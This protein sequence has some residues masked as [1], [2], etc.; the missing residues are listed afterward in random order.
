ML[1]I[2]QNTWVS[3]CVLLCRLI[4]WL[5]LAS[6]ILYTN[7]D[8]I[9]LHLEFIEEPLATSKENF[10]PRLV[11]MNRI[12]YQYRAKP[13]C[14]LVI[15]VGLYYGASEIAFTPTVAVI[16]IQMMVY[17][18]NRYTGKYLSNSGKFDQRNQ[19]KTILVSYLCVSIKMKYRKWPRKCMGLICNKRF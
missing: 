8:L 1:Y 6:Q 11:L 15:V 19:E 9:N 4:F 5:C 13:C 14:A 12:Y 3:R 18:S 7:F 17:W 16:L 10:P 2:F